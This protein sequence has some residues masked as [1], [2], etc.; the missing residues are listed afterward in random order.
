MIV[1][2]TNQTRPVTNTA[3]PPKI[4]ANRPKGRRKAPV[5]SENTLAG[6]V[7]AFDGISRAT[8]RDGSKM[9]NPDKKYSDTNIEPR[10]EK[11][12]PNSTHMDLKASGLSLPK[13]SISDG[14]YVP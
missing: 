5:T 2:T 6:H 9:L 14:V 1:H 3:Y 12:K 13:R 4:S 8:V 7:S 10:R 11:Q